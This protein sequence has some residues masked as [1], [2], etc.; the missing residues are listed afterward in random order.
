MSTAP[1]DNPFQTP[2]AILQD[3]PGVATGEPLYRLAAVG[4]ATFFGTPVAGAWVIAQNLKR[5]GRPEQIRKTWLT[6][7]GVLL[8]AFVIAWF[9]PGSFPAAPINIV[10]LLAMQQYAKQN[11]GEELDRHAAAG[12]AFHSNW[13]AFG[14]S[15]L[16]LLA[17][18]AALFGLSLV[19]AYLLGVNA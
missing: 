19:V 8:L 9:L 17:V 1:Q 13:R 16:I 15:L 7:I 10:T 12:G 2:A 5:L 18:L 4:I 6:G 14:V 11:I 3:A